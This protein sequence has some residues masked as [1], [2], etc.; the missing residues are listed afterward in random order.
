MAPMYR[1]RAR[2]FNGVALFSFILCLAMMALWV[3]SYLAVEGIYRW[4]Q[5]LTTR[6][7]YHFD[8]RWSDGKL[9]LHREVMPLPEQGFIQQFNLGWQYSPASTPP[10]DV[11]W[12]HFKHQARSYFQGDNGTLGW[13]ESW[14]VAVR[15]GLL[16]TLSAILP[17]FWFLSKIRQHQLVQA[18]VCLTCGYDL[19]ATPDRCPECGATPSK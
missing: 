10:A 9:A 6:R 7:E 12:W 8:L 11:S 17:A 2:I 14:S 5:D 1:V 18:G 3:R 19:R 13:T 4:Q 15:I 16:A